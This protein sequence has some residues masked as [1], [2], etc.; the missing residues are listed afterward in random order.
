MGENFQEWGKSKRNSQ[1]FGRQKQEYQEF[2]PS[3]GQPVTLRSAWAIWDS[4]LKNK[5]TQQQQ[6]KSKQQQKKW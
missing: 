5:I 6:Q 4:I 3:L 2:K 1:G